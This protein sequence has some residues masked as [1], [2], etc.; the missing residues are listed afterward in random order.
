MTDIAGT[1]PSGS[2]DRGPVVAAIVRGD[3]D[4]PSPVRDARRPGRHLDRLRDRH[5]G[6]DPR[7]AEPGD[8]G[9]PDHGR[10]HHGD[11]H[12]ADH[13]VAQHRPVGRLVGR[14]HRHGL[15]PA[16]DRV[17]AEYPRHRPRQPADVDPG[18][19]PRPVARRRDRALQ[20]FIIAYIGVPSFIVTLGGLLSLRGAVWLMSSGAAVNGLNDVLQHLGGGATGIDRGTLT[21]VLAVAGCIAVIALL[22]YNR[23]QRRGSASP[24]DRCGLRRSSG[25]PAAWPSSRSRR[26]RTP[27]TGHPPSPRPTRSRRCRGCGRGAL[28]GHR[29]DPLPSADVAQQVAAGPLGLLTDSTATMVADGAP[30]S[31]VTTTSRSASSQTGGARDD[32]LVHLDL[33]RRSPVA[34]R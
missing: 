21:W 18:A 1:A 34:D 24:S 7:C 17:P 3:G 12:G 15:R 28:I 8:A 33:G 19:R 31:P 22:V 23:R 4:R 14:G 32:G 26:S 20:G 5:R 2:R 27:T 13:R 6:Q 25:W 30:A 16:D 11:G 29:R 10:R 9:R